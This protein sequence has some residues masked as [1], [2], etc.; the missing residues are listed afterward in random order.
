MNNRYK[1]VQCHTSVGPT[2]STKYKIGT[3]CPQGSNLGPLFFKIFVNDLYLNVEKT[4][5]LIYADDTTTNYWSSDLDEL[6]KVQEKEVTD[7]MYWFYAN[8]LSLNLLKTKFILY[9]IHGKK[10]PE[11]V[12]LTI[13]QSKIQSTKTVSYLGVTLD[14]ELKWDSHLRNVEAK[15]IGTQFLLN[16]S[17]RYL[18]TE[19]MKTLY[20][21]NFYS[22]LTYG[23]I[24]WGPMLNAKHK[25]SLFKY[26]KQTI[27]II[28]NAKYNTHTDP[29]F[30]KHKIHKL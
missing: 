9:N 3:G 23:N 12:H 19:A 21:S 25:K 27:R 11:L 14:H 6:L 1:K 24:S 29:I 30:K 16:V 28:D 5:A 20:Y 22:H 7:L 4:E 17:K 2:S 8:K 15:L 13:D 10:I 26:Q 18:T